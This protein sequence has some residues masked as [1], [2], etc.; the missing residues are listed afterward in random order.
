MPGDNNSQ[1]AF[2]AEF[3]F[4]PSLKSDEVTGTISQ[5]LWLLNSSVVNDRV[6]V[7]D[8]RTAQRPDPKA[9]P[10]P[11]TEPSVLKQLVSKHGNDDPAILWALY[12]Q[13]L[14]RKPTDRE[15]ETCRQYLRE[16]KEAKGT[17]HEA[18]EDILKALINTA[19]FQRKR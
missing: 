13:T 3:H 10:K 5:A 14:A 16:T 6:K 17:R 4:D 18:L 1:A 2:Q 11:I 8:V 12:L 7:G 19:E 15:L 9:P